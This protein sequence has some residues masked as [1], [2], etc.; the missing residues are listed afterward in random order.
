MTTD[1]NPL[2][3]SEDVEKGLLCSAIKSRDI[4]AYC[5]A[6][7]CP[8]MFH[9]PAHRIIFRT[10]CALSQDDAPTDFVTVKSALKNAGKLE[11]AGGPEY[12]S[13]LWDFVPSSAN[14]EHY[15]NLL[16][17]YYDRRVGITECLELAEQLHDL[18]SETAPRQIVLQTVERLLAKLEA[19]IVRERK[20]FSELVDETLERI[21]KRAEEHGVTGIRFGL[22]ML[23]EEIDGVQPGELCVISG[24]TSS[25]KSA[26]ALQ[27]IL[28]TAG[29]GKGVAIFSLEMPGTQIVERM[30]SSDGE[31]S[32]KVIRGGLFSESERKRLRASVERIRHHPIHIEENSVYNITAIVESVSCAEITGRHRVGRCRLPAT[33]WAGTV[34][35]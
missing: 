11:E 2:P 20:P 13:G 1:S 19:R 4:L 32:M 28:S 25:G 18:R 3:F 26:L 33:R 22:E 24:Q 16:F 10:L 8:E 30:L 12:L 21:E 14:W 34:A 23:D 15:S 31:I 27:A 29:E 17:E 5:S 35:S 9:I 7:L 6:S